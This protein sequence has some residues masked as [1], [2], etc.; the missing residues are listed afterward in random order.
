MLPDLRQ[1]CNTCSVTNHILLLHILMIY[2]WSRMKKIILKNISDSRGINQNEKLL[3]NYKI[4]TMKM[5]HLSQL[6]ILHWHYGCK[7][8]EK[9][10]E[11]SEKLLF[12]VNGWR[13]TVRTCTDCSRYHRKWLLG[14]ST[15][16]GCIDA[17][18]MHVVLSL[19]SE[20]TEKK[21]RGCL[22]LYPG[23]SWWM[24]KIWAGFRASLKTYMAPSWPQN[25]LLASAVSEEPRKHLS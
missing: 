17:W 18:N 9:Q 2:C 4:T 12:P 1:I 6:N 14:C 11:L 15:C 8:G 5:A 7:A 19:V 22:T 10:P 13:Q 23:P 16:S 25:T 20:T 21:R 3:C 24:A